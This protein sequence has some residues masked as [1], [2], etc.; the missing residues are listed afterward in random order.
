MQ[1]NLVE[2]IKNQEEPRESR[3]TKN[4]ENQESESE[5]NEEKIII[6]FRQQCLTD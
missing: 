6:I 2:R 4:Q 5:R 1:I 3:R